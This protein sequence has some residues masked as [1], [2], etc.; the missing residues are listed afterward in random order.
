[1][2]KIELIACTI[3]AIELDEEYLILAEKPAGPASEPDLQSSGLRQ[4]RLPGIEGKKLLCAKGD[5]QSDVQQIEA[6]NAKRFGVCRCKILS[7]T[8]SVSPWNRRMHQDIIVQIGLNFAERLLA[9]FG[10]DLVPKN[11]EPNASSEFVAMKGGEWERLS[12]TLHIRQR[13]H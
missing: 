3:I 13:L 10:G 2:R 1:M 9:L 6:P 11:P 8:E 12:K 5:G 4:G 7:F